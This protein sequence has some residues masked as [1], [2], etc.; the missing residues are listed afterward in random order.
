MRK[1]RWDRE[2]KWQE[3]VEWMSMGCLIAVI[4]MVIL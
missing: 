2:P 3:P 4:I 1:N